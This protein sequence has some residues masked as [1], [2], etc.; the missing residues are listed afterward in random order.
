MLYEANKIFDQEPW[1]L[2]KLTP[3]GKRLLYLDQIAENEFILSTPKGY[4]KELPNGKHEI[5]IS[6][7]FLFIDDQFNF[8]GNAPLGRWDFE[9]MRFRFNQFGLDHLLNMDFRAFR[10]ATGYGRNFM[11]VSPLRKVLDFRPFCWEAP[12]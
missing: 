2:D 10:K 4:V 1:P 7:V 9:D 5:C 3:I 11:I 12:W 6:D 8:D